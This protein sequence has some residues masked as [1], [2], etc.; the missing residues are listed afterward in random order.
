VATLLNAAASRLSKVILY[1]SQSFSLDFTIFLGAKPQDLLQ[2]SKA[3]ARIIKVLPG[4]YLLW[5]AT[6]VCTV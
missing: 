2:G 4:G 1:S 5:L 3:G 6:R